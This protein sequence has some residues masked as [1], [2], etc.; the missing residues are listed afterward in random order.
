MSKFYLTTAIAYTNAK[1]HLGHA[2]E[3]VFADIIARYYRAKGTDTYFL[4]GTDEHGSKIYKTAKEA[5]RDTQEFVDD[6]V[7]HF[8]K[9][10][11]DLN[12]TNDDFVRT[13]SDLHK[14]GAQK[15]WNKLVEADDIYL[16][17]YSGLYCSGCEAFL[18]EKDLVDG[19]CTNHMVA[20][21]LLTE[22]NYFFRLSKYSDKIK[23]L[24]KSGEL[25]VYPDVR[26]NEMLAFLNEG[27]QDVS[28]SRPKNILPWGINVP[29]DDSQVMYVWCDALTNYLTALGY[30]DGDTKVA[31][32]WP[33]DLHI[34]GKDILRFHAGV[35]IGM[36]L[37]AGLPLPKAI[38]VH[39]FVTSEGK[40][41]S[42]SLGNV[43]DPLDLLATSPV[44]AVRFYLAREIPT[45]DD[46]DFS[47]ERFNIVYSS[48]LANNFGNLA[49]RVVSMVHKY[50]NGV[51]PTITEFKFE[52]EFADCFKTYC[53]E[54]ENFDIKKGIES[55]LHF[56]TLLNQYVEETK[57]WALAKEAKTAELALVMGNLVEGVKR[58][59]YLMA[60]YVPNATLELAKILQIDLGLNFE[61]GFKSVVAEKTLG[62]IT[63]LFPRLEI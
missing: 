1:P 61:A 14:R 31:K 34:I 9:L 60:P 40:K 53:S 35:W 10:A 5:G 20:P 21:E 25:K 45:G 24:I 42:K 37:S 4:T 2:L 49:S 36:L 7:Q 47:K 19:K 17:S 55:V 27:L 59:T 48:D 51:V 33:C 6:V 12:L 41:M 43:V 16:N 62:E 56:M 39:G 52:P 50:F 29:N 63:P 22:E 46:G 58:V 26:K 13:S 11:K 54:I 15:I 18:S 32:Y 44:D 57:P 38:G 28:F 30:A 3:F 8:Y 23:D